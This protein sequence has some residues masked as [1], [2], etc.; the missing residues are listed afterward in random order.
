M[1]WEAHMDA[2]KKEEKVEAAIKAHFA[3]FDRLKNAVATGQSEFKPEVVAKDNQCEFGKWI[4]SDLSN[5][6][7]QKTFAEIK[8]NHAKF[9]QKASEVLSLALAG[10]KA[11]A[12]EELARTGVLSQL[13]GRLILILRRL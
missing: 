2:K 8:E 1:N 10:N 11:K 4:Y 7:D 12:T 13:S 5:L 3:W 6:C 9:H